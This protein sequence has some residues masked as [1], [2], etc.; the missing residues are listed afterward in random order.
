MRVAVFASGSGSNFEA[1]VSAVHRQELALEVALLFSDQP[2]A[3]VIQRAEKWG[4]PVV[5]FSPKSFSSR[6]A[7][8]NDVLSVL[9]AYE[10]EWIVLA[11]YMRLIGSGLLKAY[12]QKIMNI[13]PSLL[14]A[15]PGLHGIRDAFEAGVSETGVTIHFIDEGIDTGPI[16]AQEKVRILPED[17]VVSLE[18]RI[19]Q[20]EHR[21][22]VE[23]LK[24]ISNRINRI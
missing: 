18:D 12:P 23:V 22:Y 24:A 19:H 16:I 14:P 11:G 3:P 9:A 5:T 2:E 7:Y 6:A 21:L 15:F 20:V 4:I 8:E 13:H 10:V 1:I 17:D